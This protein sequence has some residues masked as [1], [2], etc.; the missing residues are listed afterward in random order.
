MT[1]G[2]PIL[3]QIAQAIETRLA[4][5][6]VAAGYQNTITVTRPTRMGE[7]WTPDD[8]RVLLQ[9]G[10][11]QRNEEWEYVANPQVYAWDQPFT[12]ELYNSPSERDE[13]EIQQLANVAMAD[14]I[15]ALTIPLATWHTWGG[16]AG[17]SNISDVSHGTAQDG[18]WHV[19]QI[20]LT[21]TYRTPFNNPYI[22][23]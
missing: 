20:T 18:S 5:V 1:T 2:Y 12:I 15:T 11:P 8:Y 7:N 22:T 16:I 19:T 21:V 13:T 9:A 10:D 14:I 4:G 3:E 6:T 17:D 23:A